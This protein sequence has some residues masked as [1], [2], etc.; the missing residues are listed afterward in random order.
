MQFVKQSVHMAMDNSM[1]RGAFIELLATLS[2]DGEISDGHIKKG[3]YRVASKLDDTVLDNPS[4]KEQYAEVL[5]AAK[6]EKVLAESL[7]VGSVWYE[8]TVFQVVWHI[9][10]YLK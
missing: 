1:H 2:R 3:F 7:S 8:V 10:P 5:E 6:T 9:V 4:A